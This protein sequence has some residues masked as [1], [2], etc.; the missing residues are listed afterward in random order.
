MKNTNK[1]ALCISGQPRSYK[2]G[3][4]YIKKN[5]LDHYDVDVFYHSWLKQ[6]IDSN[7]IFAEIKQLYNPKSYSVE[8]TLAN[9]FD[10]KYLRIPNEKFPAYFTVSAFYSIYKANN[11]KMLFEKKN[12]FFYDW[13]IRIRFDYALNAI[14][15][16]SLLEKNKV[17]IPNCRMVPE[18]NFGNDQFA[19]G[20]SKVIDMYSETYLN[21]DEFYNKGTVMIGEDMLRENLTKHNLIGENLVYV[22]MNNPFPPG[23]HNGTWHSL[24][25]DDYENWSARK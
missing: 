2:I 6:D 14:P 8:K 22:D 10:D 11:L 18:R 15:D 21:L 4:E 24:I 7:N 9:V 12:N 5:L 25:R 17:Y 23:K 1:M 20:S 13:V 3:F 16:F 19:M